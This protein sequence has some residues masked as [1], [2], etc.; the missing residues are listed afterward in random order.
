MGGLNGRVRR[1]EA[2]RRRACA[3]LMEADRIRLYE[4]ARRTGQLEL[5]RGGKPSAD[6]EVELPE[7]RAYREVVREKNR[8][9][10][11]MGLALARDEEDEKA[12]SP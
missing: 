10:G 3:P 9:G 8:L 6:E 11:W 1:L 12:G 4:K 5:I 7:F 2:S